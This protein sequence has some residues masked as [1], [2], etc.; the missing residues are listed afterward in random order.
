MAE[1][2]EVGRGSARFWASG[3]CGQSPSSTLETKTGDPKKTTYTNTKGMHEEEGE[4]TS[5]QIAWL[6]RGR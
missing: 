1:A 4:Q 6:V 3:V 2:M 5:K